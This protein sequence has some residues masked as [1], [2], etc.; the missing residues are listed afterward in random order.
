MK[1]GL[2]IY[3]DD[4]AIC[5]RNPG[6][7]PIGMRNCLREWLH[8]EPLRRMIARTILKASTNQTNNWPIKTEQSRI[9]NLSKIGWIA[10]KQATHLR[11]VGLQQILPR[12]DWPNTRTNTNTGRGLKSRPR[13]RSLEPAKGLE[14]STKALKI[15]E[16][17]EI[18]EKR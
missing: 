11:A 4:L 2:E 15:Q 1:K 5:A 18:D 10:T 8:L 7:G 17:Q 9:S 16:V 6:G 3:L 13:A 14:S 12:N